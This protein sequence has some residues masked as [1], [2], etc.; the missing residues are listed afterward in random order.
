MRKLLTLLLLSAALGWTAEVKDRETFN[1]LYWASKPAA[2]RALQS[3]PVED[4]R[5]QAAV[6]LAQQGYQIDV[7]VHVWGFDP[8]GT[9]QGRRVNGFKWVPALLQNFTVAQY[10]LNPWEL[11]QDTPMPKGAIKTSLDD[12]DYPAF[13]PPVPV[14]PPAKPVI[15]VGP[16]IYG[17]VYSS[18]IGDDLISYPIGNTFTDSRGTFKKAGRQTPF[19]LSAWWEKQ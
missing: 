19:G 13:D 14:A 11:S 3:M 15:P 10:P 12:A 9:M 1:K 5:T 17:N 4:A 7:M 6:T 2:V 8:W 18:N 16:Q